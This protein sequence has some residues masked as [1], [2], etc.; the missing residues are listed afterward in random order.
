MLFL[1]LFA[2]V[3]LV[4]LFIFRYYLWPFLF[5]MISYVALRPIFDRMLLKIKNRLLCTNIIILLLFIVIIVPF[6]YL[7]LSLADQSYQFYIFIQKKIESGLINDI[8][9]LEIVE[10]I[11]DYFGLNVDVLIKKVTLMAQNMA[12]SA[13]SSITAV[14]TFSF[15][16]V[17]NFFFMILILFFLLKD[18][19]RVK[20]FFFD[21]SPFP[22]DIENSIIERLK[23]VIKVLIAGNLAIML[24]QGLMLGLGLYLTGFKIFLLWGS[25]GSILSLIPVVGTLI[26]WLPAGLYLVY[27]GDIAGG[28]FL[29]GWSLFWYLFLENLVK[30]KVFGEKLKF[31]PVLFFFLLLGSIQAFNLPGVLLGP[32]IMTLFYSLL[33]IYRFLRDLDFETNSCDEKKQD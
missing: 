33:E 5:A 10:K 24:L 9:H 25:L 13:F 26:I 28:I 3:G 27:S 17:L 20:A 1:A 12:I 30:P 11:A 14:L 4:L 21:V 6:F 2:T 8:R 19:N 32:I 29:G 23:E 22:A 31:H 16:L 18:G 15:H 7:L